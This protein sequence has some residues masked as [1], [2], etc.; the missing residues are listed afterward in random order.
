MPNPTSWRCPVRYNAD[1]LCGSRAPSRGSHLRDPSSH[2]RIALWLHCHAAQ[3]PHDSLKASG[4][5]ILADP[6]PS[7]FS[8]TFT[9][10]NPDGHAVTVHE[11]A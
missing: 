7:P 2:L 3:E 1:P 6:G 8:P 11:K 4:T 9:F 5:F 10:A